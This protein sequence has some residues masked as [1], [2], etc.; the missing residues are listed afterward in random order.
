MSGNGGNYVFLLPHERA[1]VVVT[2][3]AYNRS[4]AHPQ[5]R[6]ILTGYLL[7][8]V[9]AGPAVPLAANALPAPAPAAR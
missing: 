9:D 1:V 3:Q 8:A 6:R 2:T 5:S 4:F 7:P